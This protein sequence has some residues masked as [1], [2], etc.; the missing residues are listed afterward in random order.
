MRKLPTYYQECTSIGVTDA[1][2]LLLFYD[3]NFGISVTECEQG[4]KS[5]TLNTLASLVICMYLHVHLTVGV[6]S[7]TLSPG[8]FLLMQCE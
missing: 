4:Q 7:L 5:S 1:K 2:K 3:E 8:S 6:D